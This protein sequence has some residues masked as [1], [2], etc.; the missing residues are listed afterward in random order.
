VWA[1]AKRRANPHALRA[2]DPELDAGV[3]GPAVL[4]RI[5]CRA[6][7]IRT[8]PATGGIVSP[9]AAETLRQMLPQLQ[10]AYIPG[11]SRSIR[12]ANFERFMAVVKAFLAG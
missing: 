10:I 2:F 1:D 4:G 12:R 7:L 11:A 8:D 9:R 3:A 5:T 6:L